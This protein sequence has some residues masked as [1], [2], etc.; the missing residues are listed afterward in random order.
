MADETEAE[1]P[2][3]SS[4]PPEDGGA[5][6]LSLGSG[7]P[8]LR[9]LHVK[10]VEPSKETA[11]AKEEEKASTSEETPE[12]LEASDDS[13]DPHDPHH[14]HDH[15][16]DPYHHDDYHDP[17][18]EDYYHEH[19]DLH[20]HDP[21]DDWWEEDEKDEED[22]LPPEGEMSLLDHLEDLR[23]TLF[24]SIGALVLGCVIVG[25]NVRFFADILQQPI[26]YAVNMS[27]GRVLIVTD[28]HE[29]H[30]V[31]PSSGK[32]VWVYPEEGETGQVKSKPI[33]GDKKSKHLYT[34]VDN[35]VVALQKRTGKE[36][37]KFEPEA[38]Q[39]EPSSLRLGAG[40]S[41]FI[42]GVAGLSETGGA[43]YAVNAHSGKKDW[44]YSTG[45]GLAFAPLPDMEDEDI[46][47]RTRQPLGVM[48]VLL[49]VV[50]FGGLAISLPFI[51]MFVSGFVA[52]GLTKREKRMLL[53][54][55]ITAVVLFLMG[56]A[57][58]FFFIVP[59]S[60]KFS[61]VLNDWLGIELL[62][63]VN[64]YYSLVVMVT[65]AVG[66]LFQFP[67]LLVILGYLGVLSAQKLRSA[68]QIVFVI[69]LI[70]AALLTPGDVIVALGLLT[71]PLY[72]MFEGSILMVA[73]VEK[74]KAR[75]QARIEARRKQ[76]EEARQQS[77]QK[78]VEALQKLE[79]K[80]TQDGD[81]PSKEDKQ[82]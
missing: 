9:N 60:L 42:S 16:H 51:V 25:V 41:L 7:R 61:I 55:S 27:S 49:Q 62:F 24:K 81:K 48:M 13:T 32:P 44:E 46:D 19:E 14:D 47:L 22:E 1:N 43:V 3:E 70:V 8:S 10:R 36:V 59:V 76:R 11:D 23:W 17:D 80:P 75:K 52:P 53:P 77:R 12:N 58:A 4:S 39:L 2:P 40:E 6:D 26:E 78:A 82:K 21:E 5:A 45:Q 34:V 28:Q 30:S 57:L 54:G 37:W 38:G 63:D 79:G 74:A 67:L 72:G 15:D 31:N 69:I 65:L 18:H 64:D 66:A 73:Y 56:A 20:H 33:I 71:V 29:L 50:F 35:S 68:R